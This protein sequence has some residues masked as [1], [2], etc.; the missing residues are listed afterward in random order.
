MYDRLKAKLK[1]VLYILTI[2]IHYR[3][4]SDTFSSWNFIGGHYLLKIWILSR[5]YPKK[6]GRSG[7]Q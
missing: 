2:V 1:S 4:T 6:N 5:G 7:L 3:W